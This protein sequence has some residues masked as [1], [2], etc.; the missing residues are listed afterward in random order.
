MLCSLLKRSDCRKV[1]PPLMKSD[2][3]SCLG[4]PPP[5]ERLSACSCL[6]CLGEAAS[7]DRLGGTSHSRMGLLACGDCASARSCWGALAR[8]VG[9]KNKHGPRKLA[10]AARGARLCPGGS[11][12]NNPLVS[13]LVFFCFRVNVCLSAFASPHASSTAAQLAHAKGK[14][15]GVS[16]ISRGNPL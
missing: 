4:D 5:S 11:A 7:S 15:V 9:R 12:R 2:A 3:S 1:E 6:W 8:S 14:V 10:R 13:P 16:P